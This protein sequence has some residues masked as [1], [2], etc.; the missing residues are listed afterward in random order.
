MIG[1]GSAW[2]RKNLANEILP[3]VEGEAVWTSYDADVHL[4]REP[5]EPVA[6]EDV[7]IGLDFGRRPAAVFSQ[8]I[9][10]QRQLQFELT[11][12]NAGATRMAPAVRAMLAK[13]YPWVLHGRG[14]LRAWG[15]PKGQDGTQTD[16]TTAYD[17]FRANGVT[18][19]PAPVKQNNIRTRVEAVS[20]Q[21]ERMTQGRPALMVSP[22]CA[23]L[24]MAMA[25]G[26]RY[27]KERPSPVEERKPV[28]DRFSDIA[29]ALQYL[30]LGEGGGREMVGRSAAQTARPVS[31][32][33]QGHSLRRIGR[34]R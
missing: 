15:D 31:T 13:H 23:R 24:K 18:V 28:K 30:V 21:L 12:E 1:K 34:G 17:V 29:D 2:I 26:Y 6:N 20:F 4:A 8:V 22:R 3:M 9:G 32:R 19:R 7:A 25:G 33:P 16:E 14:Q 10:G 27:P 5:L 11:M